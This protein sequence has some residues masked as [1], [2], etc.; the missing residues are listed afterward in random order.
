MSARRHMTRLLGLLALLA[1]GCKPAPTSNTE[2]VYGT[3]PLHQDKPV[4]VF[5]VNPTHNPSRMFEIFG[6]LV[7]YINTRATDF[8]LRFEA[9]ENYGAFE[10][11]LAKRTLHFALANPYQTLQ[12]EPTGYRVFAKRGDDDRFCGLLIVRKDAG[13]TKISDLKGAVIAF[14]SAT[15]MAAAMMQKYYLK[16]HGLDVDKEAQPLYVNNQDSA[17]MNVYQ[18]RAKAAAT[19]PPSWELFAEAN[20]AVA[21]ALVVKWETEPLVSNSLMVRDD[22]PEA[23][24]RQVREWLVNLHTH[25][26]G[27][28]LL[29]RMK[30]ARF[31]PATSATY[32]PVRE[33]LKKYDAA[34]PPSAVK[35]ETP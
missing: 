14:P 2:P 31:D 25:D 11:K 22:V 10:E 27:R 6:P 32:D 9:S 30:L 1:A 29:A 18:G 16:M 28:A 7:D 24:W 8:S 20:P 15:S 23:H 33:F 12:A 34:F 17:L 4:Y 3:K 5:A 35:K 13:I 26:V 21:A 19:W